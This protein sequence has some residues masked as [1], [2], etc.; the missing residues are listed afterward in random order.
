MSALARA[1][2][3]S[4]TFNLAGP[5]NI[6]TIRPFLLG[7][8]LASLMLTIC[9]AQTPDPLPLHVSPPPQRPM[10]S[11]FPRYEDWSFLRDPASR[12]DRF[13][14]LKFLP[15]NRAKTNYL[16][17]GAE[18][19]VEFQYLNSSD[20]GAGPQDHTGYVL[21]RFMPD[22]DLRI[23]NHSR[24]F[25]TFKFD[26][27]ADKEAGP[28]PGIDKDIADVHEAFVEFGQ[29]LH[30]RHSGIDVVLGR[31]EIVLGTGRLFDDNEG[32]NVRNSFDGVRIGDDR[33]WGR[34]DVF[35]LKPVVDNAGA[36]DDVP[37][38][39]V[40]V[41]GIYGSNIPLARQAMIDVYYLGLDQKNMTYG[42][43]QGRE[44]RHS[45]GV[46]FFNRLPGAEPRAGF[47]YN[48]EVVAQ[49]GAFAARSIHAWGGGSELGWTFGDPWMVRVGFRADA[50]SGD[51]DDPRTLGTFNALYPR[52]AFFGPKFALIGP[53]N[54]LDVQP[55]L[56]FHPFRNVTGTAEWI[57]FWRESIRDGLYSFQDVP[58]RPASAATA[59]YVG[60]QPNLEIRIAITQHLTGA[61]NAAGSF[62][63]TFLRQSPPAQNIAFTNAGVTYRF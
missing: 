47:D 29:A 55:M 4:L 53:A 13:D 19:R 2:R 1:T 25:L 42:T 63:G 33:P 45:M 58:L 36:W 26:D 12:A 8:V 41:W 51:H 31:Q 7:A 21:H 46:R 57:W 17:L 9:C 40:T 44:I 15:L 39:A 50:I 18:D 11:P 43:Q 60:D 10:L 14:R 5:M 28:R 49:W 61:L 16:T 30:E 34:V 37:N 52:G 38:H 56:E 20:W 59:R 62:P 48:A 3:K 24:A 6:H 23:G 32:V 22:V 54:L 27:V 35:A